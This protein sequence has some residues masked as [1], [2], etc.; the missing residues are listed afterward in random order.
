QYENDGYRASLNYSVMASD[1]GRIRAVLRDPN[2]MTL[3]EKNWAGADGVYPFKMTVSFD[4]T[5]ENTALQVD[6]EG[7]PATAIFSDRMGP[8]VGTQT[9]VT[10]KEGYICGIVSTQF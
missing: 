3:A 8:P 4:K 5:Q 2:Y 10:V 6:G 1:G 7:S 9:V